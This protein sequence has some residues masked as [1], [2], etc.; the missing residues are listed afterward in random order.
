MNKH[1]AVIKLE[2]VAYFFRTYTCDRA[3][4]D[5]IAPLPAHQQLPHVAGIKRNQRSAQG[6]VNRLYGRKLSDK[7]YDEASMFKH[8]T[9]CR[10]NHI[11]VKRLA[12]SNRDELVTDGW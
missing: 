3:E 7:K 1:V 8:F 6:A 12:G 10:V 9:V 5:S 11:R 2:Q 4:T